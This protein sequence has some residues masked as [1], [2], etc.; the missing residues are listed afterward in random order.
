MNKINS[1]LCDNSGRKSL[2]RYIK[3]KR[4]KQ[5]AKHIQSNKFEIKHLFI[6]RSL[7]ASISR[8]NSN[9]RWFSIHSEVQL[10][11]HLMGGNNRPFGI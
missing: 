2:K 6:L 8:A 1:N 10:L 5:A 3:I 9:D 4:N 11:Y 7:S